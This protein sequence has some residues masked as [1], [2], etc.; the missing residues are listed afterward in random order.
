M[1]LFFFF[2]SDAVWRTN[3]GYDPTIRKHYE[4]SDSPT[5]WTVERYFFIH[6]AIA[7]YQTEDTKIGLAQAINIT[8][9]VG[10]KGKHA[11]DCQA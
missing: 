1:Y 7:T 4:W 8:S 5:S 9:I 3:H 6:D 11:Y 10:D 2:C